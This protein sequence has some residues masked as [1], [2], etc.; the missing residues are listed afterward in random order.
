[1]S[2][3]VPY[4]SSPNAFYCSRCNKTFVYNRT[5]ETPPCP[6]CDVVEAE[7]PDEPDRVKVLEAELD[8]YRHACQKAV[9]AL[10]VKRLGCQATQRSPDDPQ[11]LLDECAVLNNN[12][13]RPTSMQRFC[14]II[15]VLTI[16][17]TVCSSKER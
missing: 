11:A 9:N 1:M 8:I 3:V 15:K 2:F 6:T 13:Y 5:L 14:N 12:D 10:R 16:S 4:S 7:F 17:M